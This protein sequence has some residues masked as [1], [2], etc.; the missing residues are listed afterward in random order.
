MPIKLPKFIYSLCFP[1]ALSV[2]GTTTLYAEEVD[3]EILMLVDLS[4]SVDSS[5][6]SQLMSSYA[7]AFRDSSVLSNIQSGTNGSIAASLVFFSG[8]FD[9]AVAVDWMKIDDSASANTFATAIEN[10]VRPFTGTS[11]EIGTAIVN[12]YTSIGDE[13]ARGAADNGFSSSKQII[14]ITGDGISAELVVGKKG[15]TSIVSKADQDQA[16][17]AIVLNNGI[18]Q[19]NS[20]VIEPS[21]NEVADYY[22]E[23]INGGEEPFIITSTDYSVQ[24]E[25]ITKLNTEI[26]AANVPEPSSTALLGLSSLLILTRRKR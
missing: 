6:Y 19:I 23:N 25:M 12:N 22:R 17:R 24:A 7:G 9:N 13:T 20:L 5:A 1:L 2:A 26:S 14:D 11:T 21:G 16:N 10:A 8:A 15:E 18:D 3:T 4:E